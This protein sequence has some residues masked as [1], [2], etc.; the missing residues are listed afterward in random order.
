MR[1][2]NGLKVGFLF[3]L[4]IPL[5]VMFLVWVGSGC[6]IELP[7]GLCAVLFFLAAIIFFIPDYP[8]HDWI[9]YEASSPKIPPI[10]RLCVFYCP[11]CK[12]KIKRDYTSFNIEMRHKMVN[13]ESYACPNC[14]YHVK[15][16]YVDS[17]SI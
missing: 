16:R 11:S 14:P 6:S 12:T 17:G 3:L 4:I 8:Q 5:I 13:T 15:V 7:L 2:N 10:R 1:I 9:E